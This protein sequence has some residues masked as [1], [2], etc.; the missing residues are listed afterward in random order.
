MS[1]LLLLTKLPSNNYSGDEN[2]SQIF[3]YQTRSRASLEE[4]A[5]SGSRGRGR[6]LGMGD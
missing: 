4:L 3:M 6:G 5:V 2:I 1:Q